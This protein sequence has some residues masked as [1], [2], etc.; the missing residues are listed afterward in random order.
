MGMLRALIRL[1]DLDSIENCRLAAKL[2]FNEIEERHG[3]AAATRILTDAPTS[4]DSSHDL[5]KSKDDLVLQLYNSMKRP[6]V[7][8][9]ARELAEANNLLFPDERCGPPGS[10]SIDIMERYIWG[11]LRAQREHLAPTPEP[12]FADN[13]Q[14][15]M[16]ADKTALTQRDITHALELLE[17]LPLSEDEE[18][19][20]PTLG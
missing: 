18:Q 7:E 9:L 12:A 8:K 6:S 19:R 14:I 13:T 4:P 15:Q 3:S 10:T 20:P 11:L 17:Q 2:L 16:P 1:L 5:K